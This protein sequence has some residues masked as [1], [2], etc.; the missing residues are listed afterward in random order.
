[1]RPLSAVTV[2]TNAT[3]PSWYDISQGDADSDALSIDWYAKE[4]GE[5]SFEDQRVAAEWYNNQPC[6][7]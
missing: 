1:M 5:K 6:G 3:R 2:E 4:D 7:A